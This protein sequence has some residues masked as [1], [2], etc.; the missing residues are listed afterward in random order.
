M[1]KTR[2]IELVATKVVPRRSHNYATQNRGI[3]SNTHTDVR[4]YL[5][6]YDR[7]RFESQNT[8]KS[9]GNP[10]ENICCFM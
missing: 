3:F 8:Q 10:I 1:E 9:I 6:L 5:D 4:S 7:C 2:C